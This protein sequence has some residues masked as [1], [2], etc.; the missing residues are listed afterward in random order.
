MGYFETGEGTGVPQSRP[1][2]LAAAVS[3]FL[4]LSTGVAYIARDAFL[5]RQ[6]SEQRSTMHRLTHRIMSAIKTNR[7]TNDRHFVALTQQIEQIRTPMTCPQPPWT[8]FPRTGH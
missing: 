1:V 4:A 5:W 8:P 6:L 2:R 3:A 7:R